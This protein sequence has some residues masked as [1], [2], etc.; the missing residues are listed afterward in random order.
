MRNGCAGQEKS[1]F[2]LSFWRSNLIS[3]LRAKRL[4]RTREIAI[5][6]QF[7]AIKPHFVR[8][9][10]P[11]NLEIALLPQ[12]LPIEPHF[13]RGLRRTPTNRK[14]YFSFCRLNLISC[15]RVAPGSEKLQFY[16]YFWSFRA[17]RLRF[18]P[19]RWHCPAPS[20][21]KQKRRREQ[22]GGK[23]ARGQESKRATEQVG[24]M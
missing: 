16:L 13:V 8:K 5:L 9:G 24:K 22:E 15:E 12:L 19:S 14:F 7:L 3:S 17:K 1:Q 4:R 23:R 18:V 10:S 6:P 11:D 21:E 2:Y 20:R